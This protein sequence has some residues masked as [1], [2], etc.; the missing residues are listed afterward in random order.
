MSDRLDQ[1]NEGGVWLWPTLLRSVRRTKLFVRRL[2]MA[3]FWSSTEASVSYTAPENR[4]I[5]KLPPPAVQD[6]LIDLYF[7]YAHPMFPVIHK[8]LFL[9]E[10]RER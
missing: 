5:V 7:S 10:W 6:H 3:R 8:G 4:V 1:R 9:R 2:P